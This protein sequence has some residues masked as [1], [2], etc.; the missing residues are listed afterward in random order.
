MNVHNV[1]TW[2]SARGL[3]PPIVL[4]RV[5][6]RA[7]FLEDIARYGAMADDDLLR[8]TEVCLRNLRRLNNHAGPDSDLQLVL[9]PELWE[10]LRPGTRDVLRR[11]ST[12]LAEYRPDP[13]RPSLFARI[14]SPAAL[15]RLRE[16][17][18]DLRSRLEIAAR[19]DVPAL[20]EQ[21][22]FAIAGSRAAEGWSP[23]DH[24]YEPAFVYR[25]VPAIAWR[26]CQR[27]SEST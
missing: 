22:R 17:A 27:T 5:A 9:V 4:Q 24:V 23:A 3:L 15:T 16:D 25:L 8:A 11:I 12:T 18:Q 13:E 10:R 2:Q 26:A 1:G 19:L 6:G 21:T 14:L 20:V 7:A